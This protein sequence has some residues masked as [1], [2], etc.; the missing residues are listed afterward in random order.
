MPT[1]L[2]AAEVAALAMHAELDLPS[3]RLPQVTATFNGIRATL[4]A[5]DEP[6]YETTAPASIFDPRS[7][8]R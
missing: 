1:D 8:D 4:A 7:A 5:L 2:T 6:D 3:E